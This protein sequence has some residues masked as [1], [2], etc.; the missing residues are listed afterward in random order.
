VYARRVLRRGNHE[1]IYAQARITE[2]SLSLLSVQLQAMPA[3]SYCILSYEKILADDIVQ[4]IKLAE[5]LN[6]PRRFI[7]FKQLRRDTRKYKNSLTGLEL[8]ILERFYNE[9]RMRQWAELRAV[10]ESPYC[11]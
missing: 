1:D 9:R 4:N 8:E 3:D 10:A 5:Y 11:A 2:R 6:I 7:N